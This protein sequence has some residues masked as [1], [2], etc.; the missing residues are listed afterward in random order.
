MEMTTLSALVSNRNRFSV[1]F[2]MLLLLF[3]G[4]SVSEGCGQT[5]LDNYDGSG[6]LTYTTEGTWAVATG[7]YEGRTGEVTTPE[8]SYASYDLS[9]TISGWDL[10]NSNLN[11]WF[12]WMDLNKE[13]ASGWG[14]SSYCSG[15]VLVANSSDFNAATTTGYAIGFRDSDDHLV[16]FKF[17][18]GIV[19][20]TAEL[21]GTTTVIVDFGYVYADAND[22]VNFYV[23]LLSDGKWKVYYKSGAKLS[24]VNAINKANYD[25]GNAT[26]ASAETTYRG[27]AYKYSGWIYSHNSGASEKA[28][29]DNFGAGQPPVTSSSS[30][31]I[32]ASNET[33]DIAYANYQAANITATTDA[34]KVYSFTIQDGGGSVDGDSNPTILSAITFDKGSSN[35]V[36]SWANTIR[37]AALFDGSTKVAEVSVTGETIVFTGLSGANVTAADNSSK[38]LDLYLTFESSVT[39][40]Q[41]F[42]FQISNGNV[43]A[44]GSGSSTF[45]AFSSVSSSV[46]SDANRIE[47]TASDIIFDQ[48][49]S[50][51]SLGAVMSPSPTLRAIDGNINYDL[52]YASAYSV[53]VTVG[54]ATI[55]GTATTSGNFSVGVATLSNLKFNAAGTANKITVTSG[56]FADE[57]SAFDVTNPQPEINV[58]QSSTSIT[59]GGSYSFGNQLSGSS[60]SAITFTVENLGTVDLN[61]SGTPKVVLSGTNAAEF[62]VDETSTAAT[63]SASGTTTFTVI[64]SPTSQGAKTA[65]LSIANNDVTDSENPYILNLTG[66]GTVS[67]SSDITT[68]SGYSYTSNVAYAGYQ[69]ATALTTGN[70]VGVAGITIRDG[71]GVSDADNLGTTLTAISFTTGGST[72][73]RTAALFDGSTNVS[74]VA[75]NGG[76]TISFNGLNLSTADN[77]TKDLELRVTYMATVTDNQ[78]IAFT[79]SSATASSNSSGFASANAGAA[80]SSVTGDINKIEVTATQLA[81]V[82]QPTNVVTSANITPAVTV[83]A[84]DVNNNR[85]LDYVT[86]VSISAT[87][88]STS[89]VSATS[90]SGLAT[91]ST[92]S[93]AAAATGVSLNATS[94]SLTA[95]TSSLFDILLLPAAG[96]IVINQ[97]SPDYG[98]ASD[99]YIELVNRS[100]KTF[101]LSHL[102]IEYQSS[103][104]SSGSAGGNLTGSIGPY[105]YWLLSPNATITVGQTTSLS[106]DGSITAGFLPTAAQIALRLKNSPNTIID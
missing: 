43:S 23:E 16:L 70:S 64:F 52:D 5:L 31:I 56:S 11:C 97:I 54:A 3:V 42:Q 76:T 35:S 69:T 96:E 17:S 25:G 46:T 6:D 67:A 90:V 28:Y 10:Q 68:T 57:S 37:K 13:I 45:S 94:S 104:G 59:T 66:T 99:E 88:L 62:S 19:S 2:L 58:K 60:S 91:F 20:G 100:N 71:A 55:D 102:K 34:V 9:E 81:F 29:F 22:G 73:I 30:N 86:D 101:D 82:Q 83:S 49:T 41:Q 8:H 53:A 33:S 21:P 72:A 87:G 75:V 77:A 84:N 63:V 98:D 14:A 24:D 44:A 93:F 51:V 74:E 80:S 47:V 65:Q 79:V 26:S 38:T 36:T 7:Q 1:K 27:T 4:L 105:Q 40:N 15:M 92:L 18:A 89:P 12:G 78:Q 50:T 95:A 85:D 103:G 32:G 106:R 48:N 61:L 39:D